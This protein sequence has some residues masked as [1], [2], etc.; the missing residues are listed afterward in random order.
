M[1]RLPT[2]EH[3]LRDAAQRVHDGVPADVVPPR[4]RFWRTPLGVVVV[5]AGLGGTGVAVAATGLLDRGEP[6]PESARPFAVGLASIAPGSTRVMHV[7]AP[8]PDGGP[9]WGLRV[10][11]T[12]HGLACQQFGRVQGGEVGVIGR[13]G[14]F[15]NDG[16]FH[17]NPPDREQGG[18]C[19]GLRGGGQLYGSGLMS[20]IPASGYSGRPGGTVGG[21]VERVDPS[22]QSPQ[23][24][25][26]L[27]GLPVCGRGAGR[28]LLYGFAGSE[29]RTVEL[30]GGDRPTVT[31]GA[32]DS[33]A[34]LFVLRSG[35]SW[36]SVRLRYRNG[37][38][39]TA[40]F[41]EG[42]PVPD[43]MCV[44]PPGIPPPS[45]PDGAG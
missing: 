7:R 6:V 3:A 12:R 44:D 26:R 41:H 35:E 15:A 36:T 11:R 29:V 5:L 39:C 27:R 14:A 13:D 40:T 21:C 23:T 34:W 31:P 28:T 22:T 20:G 45:G 30:V 8:D 4:R 16:R 19:G 18:T 32:D 38:V 10:F 37:Y 17:E 33:G 24:R 2:L 1:T 43:R 25:R 9:P 42:R